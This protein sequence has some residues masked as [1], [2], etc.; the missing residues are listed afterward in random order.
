MDAGVPAGVAPGVPMRC[1]GLRKGVE[2]RVF[3]VW[4]GRGLGMAP[5]VPVSCRGVSSPPLS[6]VCS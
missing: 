6:G 3:G 1:E 2:R 5:R 4:I